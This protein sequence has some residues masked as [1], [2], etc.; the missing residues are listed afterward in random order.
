VSHQTILHHFGSKAGMLEAVAD[1]LSAEQSRTLE[2]LA[3]RSLPALER[4]DATWRALVT[5]AQA[6]GALY[7]Q[8]TSQVMRHNPGPSELGLR[9]VHRCTSALQKAWL[10]VGVEPHAA[11]VHARLDLAVLRGVLHDLLLTQDLASATAVMQ[12]F[13]TLSGVV[14]ESLGDVPS[15]THEGSEDDGRS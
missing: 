3:D 11:E 1:A 8:L 7:F 10:E 15:G 12:R 9:D 5:L 13:L 14:R 2:L 6:H 4:L